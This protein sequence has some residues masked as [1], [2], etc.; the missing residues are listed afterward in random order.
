MHSFLNRYP[1]KLD[2][3]EEFVMEVLQI[4]CCF[5]IVSNWMHFICLISGLIA[6]FFQSFL[7]AV[8]YYDIFD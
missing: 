2:T 7:D 4:A 8:I 5:F 1:V 6:T 3:C